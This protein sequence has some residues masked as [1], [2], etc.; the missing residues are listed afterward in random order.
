MEKR[1]KQLLY[2]TYRSFLLLYL[3]RER[4]YY[5]DNM[6]LM[7]LPGIFHPEFFYTT[8]FLLETLKTFDLKNKN[9]LELGAGTGM[10]SVHCV[11]QKA[12]VTASDINWRSIINID[13]NARWN[14]VAITIIQSDLFNNIA[15][16]KFEYV[17]INPPYIK[18]DPKKEVEHTWYCGKNMDYFSRLF[19]Q[20]PTYVNKES[21]VLMALSED[22]DIVQVKQ[23][24][25]EN[26]INMDL[27]S[28][29]K[30]FLKTNFIYKITI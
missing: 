2:F 21:T 20:L 9:I 3:K 14:R 27:F 6:R 7:V 22:C 30:S 13:K 16:Q 26:N 15:K 8:K 24:A 10:L 18:K 1:I 28:E 11:R 17:I 29:K 23:I 25:K 19:D 12:I 4:K 5:L